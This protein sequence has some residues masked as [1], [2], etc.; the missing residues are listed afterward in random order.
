MLLIKVGFMTL[1][2]KECNKRPGRLL[3]LGVL[4]GALSRYEARVRERCLFHFN[5]NNI[6]KT[7]KARGLQAE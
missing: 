6:N 2:R 1:H 4:G 3:D 5:C 7:N